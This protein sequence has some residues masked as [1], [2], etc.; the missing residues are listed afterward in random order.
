MAT[1]FKRISKVL[2]KPHEETESPVSAESPTSLEL[3]G[4]DVLT[5][6]MHVKR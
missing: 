3:L 5:N 1:V 4:I 6:H 2:V